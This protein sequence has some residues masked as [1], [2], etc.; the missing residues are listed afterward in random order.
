MT[1][2]VSSFGQIEQGAH[3]K[4]ILDMLNEESVSGCSVYKFDTA[5][6]AASI[7]VAIF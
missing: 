5:S 1:L 6:I 2:I 4:K 7:E 3:Y